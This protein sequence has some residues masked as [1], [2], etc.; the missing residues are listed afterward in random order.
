MTSSKKTQ[1]IEN[2]NDSNEIYKHLRETIE[3]VQKDNNS[4][5]FLETLRVITKAKGGMSELS[6]KIKINRQN[7][8][9]T[10]ARTG[11]PKLKSLS[12]ILEGLG[13]RLSIEPIPQD[14]DNE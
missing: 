14:N 9:R 6:K 11:N 5:D 1:Q 4:A 7:L 8:Y 12:T 3:K 10:F 13:Y 2:F